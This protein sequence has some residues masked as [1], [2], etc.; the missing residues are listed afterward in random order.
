MSKHPCGYFFPNH[1]WSKWSKP[2]K[3]GPNKGTQQ[4]HC[5]RCGEGQV[6]KAKAP[7]FHIHRWHV[8]GSTKAIR[9]RR[10]QKASTQYEC[11][12]IGCT[13]TKPIERH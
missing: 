7:R 8:P 1:R 9:G 13:A 11:K 5:N 3:R 4:R 6:R 10:L 2:F 12:I